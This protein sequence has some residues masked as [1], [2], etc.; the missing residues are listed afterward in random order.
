[1]TWKEAFWNLFHLFKN[2]LSMM[3]AREDVLN[4]RK[5]DGAYAGLREDI[6]RLV[7]QLPKE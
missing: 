3:E 2:W 5:Y 1:M 4:R 7:S 6:D